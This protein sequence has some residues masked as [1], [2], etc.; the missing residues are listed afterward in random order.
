M[1]QTPVRFD[2]VLGRIRAFAAARGWKPARLAREAGLSDTVTRGMDR[3]DWAPSGGSVRSLEGLIPEG[4]SP[5]QLLPAISDRPAAPGASAA[6][7]GE[8]G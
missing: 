5:G 6:V 4:W 1:E 2:H 8:A 7:S 3:D